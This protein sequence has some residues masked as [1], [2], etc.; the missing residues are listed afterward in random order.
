M[1]LQTIGLMKVALDK[2][3]LKPYLM[4][5]PVGFHAPD[6]GIYGFQDIPETPFGAFSFLHIHILRLGHGPLRWYSAT[7]VD[8]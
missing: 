4:V 7:L 1:S 8:P 3:G 2:E 5:Q 6:V